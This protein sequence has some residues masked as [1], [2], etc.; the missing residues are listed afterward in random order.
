MKLFSSVYRRTCAVSIIAMLPLSALADL[1]PQSVP[2]GTQIN[3]VGVFHDS[4]QPPFDE[5]VTFLFT[6]ATTFTLL[7]STVTASG[8]CAYSKTSANTGSITY[9]FT[10]IDTV[11]SY[12]YNE[13]GT[14]QITFSSAG[15][16]SYTDAGSNNGSESGVPFSGTFTANGN[17][18]YIAAGVTITAVTT[19][20]LCNGLNTFISTDTITLQ[21]TISPATSGVAVNWMVVP[22]GDISSETIGWPQNETNYTIDGV[23]TFSFSPSSNNTFDIDRNSFWTQGGETANKPIEFDIIAECVI[24]GITTQSKLSTTSLGILQQDDIDTLRQEYV[25]YQEA[26]IPCRSGVV[27]TQQTQ[28][29]QNLNNGNYNNIQLSVNL[30][31]NYTTILNAYRGSTY[32]V[33]GQ[34]YTVPMNAP[35][36][37]TSG[38]RSPQHNTAIGSVHPNSKHCY[39]RAL[40]LKPKAI[41]LPINGG[42]IR[43]GRDTF[44][45]PALQAAAGVVATDPSH[46]PIAETGCCPVLLGTSTEDHIHVQW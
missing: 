43:L 8:T 2:V 35:L 45:F 14:I 31:A 19:P 36:V 24:G 29:G 12:T 18:S 5:D 38:F 9:Q 1:A 39:G 33:N 21:A 27:S 26:T 15:A 44:W 40:D 46:Q 32:M 30:S 22:L 28:D 41:Y 16:G 11:D 37:I 4:S 10:E 6:S 23:S 20:N 34:S 25:D 42:R 3:Y 17:F 7:D 13:S